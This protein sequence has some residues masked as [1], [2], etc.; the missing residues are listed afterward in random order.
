MDAGKQKVVIKGC[1]KL[2]KDALRKHVHTVDHR[3]AVEAKAGR[4][5]MQQ[6][7]FGSYVALRTVWFMAKKNLP[8]NHFSDLK[9]FLV[10]RGSTDIGNPSFSVWS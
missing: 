10:L 6:A 7:L 9:H 4:R 8:N 3:A 1:D 2:K 5:D